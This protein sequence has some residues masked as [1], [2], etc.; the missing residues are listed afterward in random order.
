VNWKLDFEEGAKLA[1]S[2]DKLVFINFTGV[3]CTNCRW[4]EKNM[5]TQADVAAEINK[6]VPVELFTD[7]PTEADKK[8]RELQRE[9]SKVVTL[10]VYVVATPDGTAIRIFQGSTRDKE[11][12]LQFL[13]GAESDQTAMR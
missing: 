11:A 2:E 8:N 13:K 7:R 5:F 1:K 9:L 4:M 10:P 12:F 6:Y 3:T